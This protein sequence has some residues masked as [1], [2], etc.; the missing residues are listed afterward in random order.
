M[1]P[2]RYASINLH[3]GA[4]LIELT[5]AHDGIVHRRDEVDTMEDPLLAVLRLVT[6]DTSP[7][8]TVPETAML[9]LE[10]K[11]QQ[12]GIWCVA[13]QPWRLSFRNG[14]WRWTWSR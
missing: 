2:S 6:H 4:S 12:P 3:L 11:S 13:P 5:Q 10:K 14:G 7:N 1:S 8:R 9:S